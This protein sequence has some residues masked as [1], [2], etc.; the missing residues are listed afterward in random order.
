M[1]ITTSTSSLAGAATTSAVSNLL[2]FAPR[3]PSTPAVEVYVGECLL[4]VPAM[5]AERIGRWEFIEMSAIL[6]EFWTQSRSNES[7]SKPTTARCRRQ[8][9]EIFTWIQCFGRMSVFSG[10]STQ[11][12]C[13]N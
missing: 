3:L 10:G 13:Q 6:P 11:S 1:G 9:T 2:P 5:L 8:V 4:P 12:P 7:E